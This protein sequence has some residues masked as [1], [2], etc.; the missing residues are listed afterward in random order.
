MTT[1]EHKDI[2][3]AVKMCLRAKMDSS[4]VDISKSRNPVT[5]HATCTYKEILESLNERDIIENGLRTQGFINKLSELLRNN[6][7]IHFDR[8]REQFS[9]KNVYNDIHD[10]S[11]RL[12]ENK[13]GVMYDQNLFDDIPKDE[14]DK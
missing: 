10:L 8:A 3:E 5:R 1:K 6:T 9:F 11:K 7:K 4:R 12:F 2:I 14:I 13:V